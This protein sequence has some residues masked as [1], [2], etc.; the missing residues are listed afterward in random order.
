MDLEALYDQ[1][2][3]GY[4][5]PCRR[6]DGTLDLHARA[7][8]GD[9]MLHVAVGR[10][11]FNAIRYLLE[12]GLDVNAQGDYH[13][14][15][16][17]SAAASHDIGLVGFLLQMGADPNI[18]DHRGTFP[19]EALFSRLKRLPESS[20]L[21]LSQWMSATFHDET[22]Q[23]QEA[24]QDWLASRGAQRSRDANLG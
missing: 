16:I 8:N 14:T 24:E 21:R 12:A 2:E 1:A 13:E 7:A 20:L 9:T 18:P 5:I 19:A 22:T 17:Y 3:E 23:N 10:R 11:D 4:L 15:P 6:G